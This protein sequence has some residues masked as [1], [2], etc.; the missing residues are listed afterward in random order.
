MRTLKRAARTVAASVVAVLLLTVP[1][2]GSATG[3]ITT[4]ADEFNPA[5]T[6]TYIAWN[7]YVHKHYVVYAKQF[8][9]ARFRVNPTGTDA[10]AGSIDGTT[11]TYQQWVSS[12]GRS[13][14]YTYDL[15]AKTRSKVGSPVSTDRWEYD[16]VASGDW[17]MFARYYRNAD[18]KIFLFN[19]STL[20]LRRLAATSGKRWLLRSSQVNGNYAVWEKVL[21][22]HGQLAGCAI[23]LYDIAGETATK[24]DNPNARCQYASSVNPA[25]T[26]YFARSGFGCGKNV[27]LRQE[28]LGGS[29]TTIVNFADNHDVSNLYAVDNGDTTT[30]VYYDPYRCGRSIQADIVKVTEP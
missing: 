5:A 7:V 30:D 15:V 28:P 21:L 18:R 25:G 13:D 11:L 1:A 19:T 26:V 10:W 22:R 9:G 12:K 8:G 27:V 24:L 14:I 29:A 3:V 16:G 2:M 23:F 20:E 4:K 17:V 6:D